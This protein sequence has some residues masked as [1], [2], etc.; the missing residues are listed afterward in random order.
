MNF[1]QVIMDV[2]KEKAITPI[3]VEVMASDEEGEEVEVM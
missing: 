1:A 2:T 3:I